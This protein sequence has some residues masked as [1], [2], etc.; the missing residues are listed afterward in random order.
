[1]DMQRIIHIIR[2]IFDLE[3]YYSSVRE[4][5]L[6]ELLSLGC[7]GMTVD[8]DCQILVAFGP[9]GSETAHH[10]DQLVLVA[11]HCLHLGPVRIVGCPQCYHAHVVVS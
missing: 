4:S 7:Q 11:A 2:R 1:M 5:L 6:H 9:V 8:G 10:R 3:F